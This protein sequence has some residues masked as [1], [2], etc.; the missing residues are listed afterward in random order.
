MFSPA[1]RAGRIYPKLAA[2]VPRINSPAA[3]GVEQYEGV[4]HGLDIVNA[5][6]LHALSGQGQGRADCARQRIGI[7]FLE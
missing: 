5:E 3:A 4:A 6:D 2:Q 7:V 1:T